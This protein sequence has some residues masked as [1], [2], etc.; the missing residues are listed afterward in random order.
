MTITILG[1]VQTQEFA[2]HNFDEKGRKFFKWVENTV[3][4]GKIACSERFCL[5][6]LCFQKTCNFMHVKTRACFG[7]EEWFYVL[8]LYHSPVLERCTVYQNT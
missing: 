8:T 7:K 6:L 5:F 1:L 2:Y 3:E 4:K